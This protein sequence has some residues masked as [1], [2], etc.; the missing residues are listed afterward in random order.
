MKQAAAR[1]PRKKMETFFLVFFPRNAILLF[2]FFRVRSLALD[3]RVIVELL[4]APVVQRLDN[5]I[6][7]ISVNKTN[8]AIHWIVTYPM[9]SVIPSKEPGPGRL[10]I[11]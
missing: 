1:L 5:A 3:A 11:L 4:L 8:R 10:T 7:W 6:H 9:D 2:E